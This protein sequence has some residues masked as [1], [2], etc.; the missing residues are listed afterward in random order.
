MSIEIDRDKS[1]LFPPFAAVLNVFEQR[2]LERSLPFYLFEGLRSWERQEELYAQGRTKP[3][4]IVT[5]AKPGLSYHFYGLAADYVM[6]GMIE[7]PGIQWSWETR[8]HNSDWLNMAQL[9]VSC[10]L[11]T[12][13]FWRSFP[14]L[15]HVQMKYGL[16]IQKAQELF[17]TGGLDAVWDEAQANIEANLWP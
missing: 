14:E 11:E 6:D 4:K 2:L 12:A 3:G 7:K 17:R 13:Y 9:A 8:G 5:N 16:S 1:H 10:G 15:P